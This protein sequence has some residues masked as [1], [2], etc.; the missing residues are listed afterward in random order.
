MTM[1]QEI[2]QCKKYARELGLAPDLENCENIVHWLV[3]F[4]THSKILSSKSQYNG[5]SGVKLLIECDIFNAYSKSFSAFQKVCSLDHLDGQWLGPIV[6][7]M[8]AL[9]V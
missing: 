2:V 7:H 1:Q 9:L 5:Q 4:L 3:H 8:C 6:D